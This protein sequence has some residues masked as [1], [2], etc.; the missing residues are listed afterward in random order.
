LGCYGR[1]LVSYVLR[2]AV[3]TTGKL[4]NFTHGAGSQ[5]NSVAGKTLWGQYYIKISK[6]THLRPFV[7]TTLNRD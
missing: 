6:Y 5:S 1:G 2:T 7:F 4:C 3:D